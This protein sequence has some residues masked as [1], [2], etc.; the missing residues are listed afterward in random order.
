MVFY[1]SMHLAVFRSV[2]ILRIIFK[3]RIISML[4]PSPIEMVQDSV[5]MATRCEFPSGIVPKF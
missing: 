5:L 1:A 3:T 2:D 4:P